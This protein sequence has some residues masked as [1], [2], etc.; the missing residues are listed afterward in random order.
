MSDFGDDEYKNMICL[1]PGH[2]YRNR[3]LKPNETV[4]MGQELVVNFWF[5]ILLKKFDISSFRLNKVF[6]T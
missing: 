3:L 4:Q 6:I 2:V 5:F 1:E